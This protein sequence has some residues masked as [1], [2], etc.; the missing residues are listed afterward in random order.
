M[1]LSLDMPFLLLMPSFNQAH[2]IADAVRSVLSQDDPDW[3]LWILDNSTDN[4]PE[5]MTQFSDPRI[6]FHH[7]SERMDP[8]SCLNWMLERAHGKY[9]SYLHTDNNLEPCY[10]RLFRAALLSHELALAYCDMH[11]IDAQG[12]RVKLF[13]RGPFD[14][15]RL[16]SF[17]TLGVPFAATTNLARR[18]GGFSAE[19]LADDV[20]FCVSS[21][22]LA[23]FVYVSEPLIEYRLH[24][25]SRTE[26]AGGPSGMRDAFLV[27]LPKAILTLEQR[28]MQPMQ[29]VAHELNQRLTE[30]ENLAR[31]LWER[32]LGWVPARWLGTFD[33]DRLFHEGVLTLPKMEPG[34]YSPPRAFIAWTGDGRWTNPIRYALIRRFFRRSREL[35][36]YSDRILPLLLPWAQFAAGALAG[37]TTPFRIRNLDLRTVWIARLLQVELRWSPRIDPSIAV[38]H[39]LHWDPADGTEM[40]LDCAQL[41]FL[42]PEVLDDR[43]S[44]R[45]SIL[46]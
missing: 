23:K 26:A 5:V 2:Y 18:L 36:R 19:D 7:I 39:W 3:Q 37:S 16:L 24:P 45:G 25:G 15:P 32:N 8:G 9:F 22:G 44:V 11:E 4:T 40:L 27:A 42:G 35:R 38:P 14:L 31:S 21:F 30:F 10:V 28:G 33:L 29:Q 17:D 43:A 46:S 1:D 41:P 13:R 6:R 34:L 20:R 12:R